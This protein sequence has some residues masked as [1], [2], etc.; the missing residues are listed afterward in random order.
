MH[1][2][3]PLPLLL[4]KDDPEAVSVPLEE[5]IDALQALSDETFGVSQSL[6]RDPQGVGQ[7]RRSE[8]RRPETSPGSGRGSGSVRREAGDEFADVGH[9]LV[10]VELDQL[11]DAVGGEREPAGEQV[12]EHHA[13]GIDVGLR[14]GGASLEQ[15][16]SH[17]RRASLRAVRTTWR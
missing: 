13:D 17:E 15:L 14:A 8:K 11:T 6:D 9:G 12:V 2:L 1:F 16:G 5:A 4:G 3:E 10:A 7:S